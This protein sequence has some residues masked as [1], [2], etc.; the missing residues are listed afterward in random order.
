MSEICT[1]AK[2]A[3]DVHG[4]RPRASK[5]YSP[6]KMQATGSNPMRLVPRR[7]SQGLE[8]VIFNGRAHTEEVI[9]QS[10]LNGKRQNLTRRGSG[11]HR[12][13]RNMVIKANLAGAIYSQRG[14]ESTH[15][16]D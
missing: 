16:P 7:N 2:R 4:K 14:V 11:S 15:S 3:S 10:K 9:R 1:Q 6:A 8:L 13:A 12:H 5:L